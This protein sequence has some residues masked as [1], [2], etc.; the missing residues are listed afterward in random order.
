MSFRPS[1]PI[2]P[3][4]GASPQCPTLRPLGKDY[5]WYIFNQPDIVLKMATFWLIRLSSAWKRV[6]FRTY[7]HK[8]ALE[9]FDCVTLDATGYVASGPVKMVVE[10]ADYNSADN[11]IDF[12][13]ATPVRAE[14]WYRTPFTGPRPAAI[15]D[16]APQ[17]DID[18]GNAGGGGLGTNASGTLPVGDTS[19][20]P[21]TPCFWVVRTWCLVARGL[22]RPDTNRR[23]FYGKSLPSAT[24]LPGYAWHLT[25]TV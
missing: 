15:D 17:A 9:A 10:K 23:G 8:L 3:V 16:L 24:P 13:C 4:H 2:R 1:K 7:L 11:C 14:P 18:S 21:T 22:G 19:S 12:E 5:D 20:L 25:C 6:K